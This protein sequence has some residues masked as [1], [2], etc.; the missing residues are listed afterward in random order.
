MRGISLSVFA[1]TVALAMIGDRASAAE[2]TGRASNSYLDL[3]LPGHSQFEAT[4]VSYRDMIAR[5]DAALA[6]VLAA[7]SDPQCMRPFDALAASCSPE[8]FFLVAQ[9]MHLRSELERESP[10]LTLAR[11]L[12]DAEPEVDLQA[13]H[14]AR[15]RSE[16]EFLAAQAGLDLIGRHAATLD[17]LPVL[18]G[19]FDLSEAA[20]RIDWI[21]GLSY[22]EYAGRSP[23]SGV[24]RKDYVTAYAWLVTG[25]IDTAVEAHPGRRFP[26][27]IQILMGGDEWKRALEVRDTVETLLMRQAERAPVEGLLALKEFHY[28]RMPDRWAPS[29]EQQVRRA[30]TLAAARYHFAAEALSS[31][32]LPSFFVDSD[33]DVNDMGLLRHEGLLLADSIRDGQANETAR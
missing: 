28:S 8:S 11:R 20:S 7:T 27:D 22:L 30:N 1:V 19:M 26:Q 21:R 10:D 23:S 33:L 32:P 16:A 29:L 3:L 24:S 9:L 5:A 13:W 31:S 4:P 14:E 2:D 18:T 6:D 25:Y 12:R 17:S 15:Q